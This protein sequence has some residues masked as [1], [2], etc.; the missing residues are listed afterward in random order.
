MHASFSFSRLA[1]LV[2]KQ[3]ME[4]ARFYLLATLAIIGL[5]A[6]LFTFW[7]STSNQYEE[8]TT[9]VFFY[10]GLLLAGCIF[11]SSAFSMLGK[12]EQGMYWLGLPASHLEKL[13]CTIFYTTI[14]FTV[15][16]TA[17]FFLVRSAAYMVIQSIVAHHRDHQWIPVR[18]KIENH[19]LDNFIY[20]AYAYF[21]VQAVYLMGSVYFARASFVVTTIIGAVI[22]FSFIYLMTRVSNH[23]APDQL[24]WDGLTMRTINMSDPGGRAF[25][26]RV[27]HVSDW[28]GQT[29]L[30]LLKFGWAPVFWTIAY[31]RLK[32]KE[33]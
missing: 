27:Y 8:Q 19:F 18:L 31:F 23:F 1:A 13:V 21:A 11:A 6:L 26:H 24:M 9:Y 15:V 7:I 33:I 32:E 30:F 10:V 22:I 16:Y 20:F 17:A 29:V 4:N 3:W 14:I 12:K 25:E 5:N 28:L 2:R